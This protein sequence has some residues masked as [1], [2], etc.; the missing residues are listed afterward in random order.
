MALVGPSGVHH[1]ALHPCLLPAK[2]E[3]HFAFDPSPET[4]QAQLDEGAEKLYAHLPIGGEARAH[5]RPHR[6]HLPAFKESI[7][8]CSAPLDLGAEVGQQLSRLAREARSQGSGRSLTLE[9]VQ[10]VAVEWLTRVDIDLI[11]IV[12]LEQRREA[13]L[14]LR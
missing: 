8:L 9:D 6:H 12:R 5:V 14:S 13:S 11:N 2:K 3:T 4:A 7:Q 1:H 10:A